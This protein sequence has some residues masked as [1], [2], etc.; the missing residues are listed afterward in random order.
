MTKT[1]TAAGRRNRGCGDH[2]A[3]VP[4]G[5]VPAH[6]V[7]GAGKAVALASLIAGLA[8]ALH[9]P[10]AL[11]Q[12]SPT[13]PVRMIVPFPPGGGADIIA[14][15]Y[16][17]KLGEGWG[18]Q[19][20]VDNR[21]GAAGNI[22]TE[23]ATKA[24]PDGYTV[25][26][27]T[28]GTMTVN[29]S[30]YPK[31]PFDVARDLAPLTKLVDVHFV[32]VAHPS[33]P[34]QSVKDLIALAR[35]RPGQIN[36]SSSG[37]GGAPHL[38]A[39]LFRSLAKVNLIHIPYKGSGPSFADLLGGHVSI[40]FDSLVQ[41]LPY[42]RGKRLRA[43]AVLGAKRSPLVPEV[44]TM[45]EAGVAGYELTNW[46]GMA[47]PA[48]TPRDVIDRLHGDFARVS[49]MADLRERLVGMGA[50]PVAS[51]PDDFAALMKADRAKWAK[52]VREAAI[53]AE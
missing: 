52:I 14:R 26:M 41:S 34:V 23:L 32:L 38:S 47:V 25:Y 18:Q 30:L 46:F 11:A 1:M 36:Y 45:M 15:I 44:P 12:F 53:R 8:A 13:K 6:A 4:G 5:G 9:M 37:A 48:G 2:H 3:V 42:V 22:G 51:K 33:L 35:A 17:Q 20:L 27:G 40:T 16:A 24:A 10:L 39:E 50:E 49:Q 19:V 21:A 28:L 31:L 43:L 29:P 7:V